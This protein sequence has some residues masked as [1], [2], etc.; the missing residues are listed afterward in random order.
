MA[1]K[2]CLGTVQFGMKY[3]VHNALGRQPTD[4]EVFAVLDAACDAGIDAFD[5][6]SVYG[7]AEE[8]LGRYRLVS[9]GGRIIS[10]LRPHVK[11]VDTVRHEMQ[12]SLRRLGAERIA[13]YMLHRAEDLDN[14]AVMEGMTEV[15]ACGW[16]EKIGVSVYRPEDALRAA[17]DSRIDAI[18]IPYNALDQRLDACGFF[19][20][21]KKHGKEIYARSAFLQG[22]LLM[23]P[24]EAEHR[25]PGSGAYVA[26]FQ[27]TARNMGFLP[28]EAA[29]LYVLRHEGIDYV[30]FGVDTAAQLQENVRLS[31]RVSEI[32]DSCGPFTGKF[33]DVPQKLIDPSL[34]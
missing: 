31:E 7:T 33:N 34:W 29:M 8:V 19:A 14:T 12:E 23:W 20:L 28:N 21:A 17:E 16:T 2:L 9:R 13:C 27:K 11:T 22:L 3:G 24:Q 15:K 25:V 4:A 32:M 10:K 18:Q 26:T 1:A 6:A 30:V 5:T